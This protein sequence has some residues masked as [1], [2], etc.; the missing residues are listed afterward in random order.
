M[1][2]HIE[3]KIRLL[4]GNVE[5]L[6]IDTQIST[7]RSGKVAEIENNEAKQK[8]TQEARDGFGILEKTWRSEFV[9]CFNASKQ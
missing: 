4:L 3:F 8:H 5:S 2:L 7:S 1:C 9:S 6:W